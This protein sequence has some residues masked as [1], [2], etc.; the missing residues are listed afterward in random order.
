MTSNTLS[1]AMTDFISALQ[2]VSSQKDLKDVFDQTA[3]SL[4]FKAFAYHMVKVVGVDGYLPLAVTT[5][6]DQWVQR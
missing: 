6:P 2:T 1:H 4:G 3:R 5:Y